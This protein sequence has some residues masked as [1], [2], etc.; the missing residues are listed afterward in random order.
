MLC[1]VMLCYV[2]AFSLLTWHVELLGKGPTYQTMVG[3][4]FTYIFKDL[5]TRAC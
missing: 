3:R 5:Y 4:A 1:Y 2:L